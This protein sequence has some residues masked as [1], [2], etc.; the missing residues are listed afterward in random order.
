MLELGTGDRRLGVFSVYFEVEIASPF[1]E[2]NRVEQE[3]VLPGL[4]TMRERND[5]FFF[6]F[7][8]ESEYVAPGLRH[9]NPGVGENLTIVKEPIRAVNVHRQRIVVAVSL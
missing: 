8:Q 4:T 2:K 5:T 3:V 7:R 1:A 9:W 6:Q